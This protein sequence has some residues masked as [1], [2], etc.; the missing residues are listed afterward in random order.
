[1]SARF[2]SRGV[3]AL[4]CAACVLAPA[5]AARGV[6][7]SFRHLYVRGAVALDVTR[8]LHGATRKLE[9]PECQRL[10]DDFTDEQGRTLRERL[11]PVTPAEYLTGV[12]FRDGEIPKGS[13]RCWVQG[14][15]AFTTA[16]TIV[17]ICGNNFRRGSRGYR[18]TAIIHE[19]LH[20]LGVREN[21]PSPAE[22]TRRV[23]DRC[24]A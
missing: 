22:I 9:K 19:M 15:A 17:F 2:N 18:E 8:A 3:L 11:G 7:P 20:T 12:Q 24:G 23:V 14:A 5:P 6:E 21:P 1:M 4:T 10:F 13:G 16:G